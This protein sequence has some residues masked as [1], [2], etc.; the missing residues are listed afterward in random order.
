MTPHDALPTT[1]SPRRTPRIYLTLPTG[2]VVATTHVL[3]HEGAPLLPAADLDANAAQH[4]VREDG[5][6]GIK[7]IRIVNSGTEGKTSEGKDGESFRAVTVARPELTEGG[8]EPKVE[9]QFAKGTGD[10]GGEDAGGEDTLPITDI[11]LV[12]SMDPDVEA[13]DGF[14]LLRVDLGQACQAGAHIELPGTASASAASAAAGAAT[15]SGGGEVKEGKEG[16]E[17]AEESSEGKEGAETKE[18]GEGTEGGDEEAGAAPEADGSRPPSANAEEA[19][20]RQRYD[21]QSLAKRD[22]LKMMFEAVEPVVAPGQLDDLSTQVVRGALAS[23]LWEDEAL[24]G[25]LEAVSI[26]PAVLQELLE[27]NPEG[28]ISLADLYTLHGCTASTPVSEMEGFTYLCYRRDTASNALPAVAEIALV[29]G[30]ERFD[31][32]A[33]YETI[34]LPGA[35]PAGGRVYLCYRRVGVVPTL[36]LSTLAQGHMSAGRPGTVGLAGAGEMLAPSPGLDGPTL[37]GGV[38]NPQ[39]VE[40]L[41]ASLEAEVI[42]KRNK[43]A[44]DAEEKDAQRDW[45]RLQ[46][47]TSDAHEE[48]SALDVQNASLQKR[49]VLLLT[50]QKKSMGD[51]FN[52]GSEGETK[53]KHHSEV[54]KQYRDA[55]RAVSNGRDALLRKQQEYDRIAMDL[56]GRLDEKEEQADEIRD[57]FNEFKNEIAASAENS[58]TGRPIPGRII[59]QF[60]DTEAGKDDE[61]SK[62]RLRNIKS[63]TDLRKRERLLRDKEQLADGLHLI[64]FEQLK[65][66]N[67]TLNEKIEERNEELH[68]LRKKTTTTV[69]VGLCVQPSTLLVWAL[70]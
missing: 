42:A 46:Q 65:I 40:E 60:E 18:G 69:Q 8:F 44:K 36:P 37:T 9:V 23:R 41:Q 17:G 5:S 51:E 39:S 28:M 14:E 1:H 59:S 2:T 35:G 52:K 34:T 70:R 13:P 7:E 58:R 19:K 27:V 16:K 15:A 6:S 54:E 50:R 33:G 29:Y 11:T 47:L 30:A 32:T 61:V 38:T 49:L 53:K 67:Q 4:E 10:E 20:M 68:K 22:A 25:V 45:Q 64:D 63:R 31:V 43:E 26:A 56:Q 66:E 3:R 48:R 12:H 62:V 24:R 57:A 21:E 55:A